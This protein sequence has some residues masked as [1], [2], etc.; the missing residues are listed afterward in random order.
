MFN[1]I[2]RLNVGQKDL[3]PLVTAFGGSIGDRAGSTAKKLH[4]LKNS[5]EASLRPGSDDDGNAMRIRNANVE[6]TRIIAD[7]HARLESAA[8]WSK[9]LTFGADTRERKGRLESLRLAE[10]KA[11]QNSQTNHQVA[12]V[13]RELSEILKYSP[14]DF[15]AVSY[16]HLT[17]PT[18]DLV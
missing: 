17:L 8:R 4:A 18:S 13:T 15:K 2:A 5:L 3:S 12:R 7:G 6:A 1:E 14:P 11:Y 9:A 16:T 10:K